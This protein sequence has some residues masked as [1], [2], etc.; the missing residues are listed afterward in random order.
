LNEGALL[1][2]VFKGLFFSD[3][4]HFKHLYFHFESVIFFAHLL[5]HLLDLYGLFVKQFVVVLSE[6]RL[7]KV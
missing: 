1:E 4:L 3:H 2:V 7:Q 6:H 5:A